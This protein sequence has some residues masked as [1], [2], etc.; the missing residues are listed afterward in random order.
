MVE[1]KKYE[2]NEFLKKE[3][4]A[5]QFFK[6]CLGA[7][8]FLNGWYRYCLWLGDCTPAVLKD[9]PETMKLVEAV[10]AFRIKSKSVPTNK[11]ANTPTGNFSGVEG[12]LQKY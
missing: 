7:D 2:K 9:M 1:S 8:E 11:L 12:L 6:K 3:P 10:R 4:Q 5:E